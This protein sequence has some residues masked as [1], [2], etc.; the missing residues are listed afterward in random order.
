MQA[1][2]SQLLTLP[3]KATPSEASEA[4]SVHAAHPA[5]TSFLR[6]YGSEARVCVAT[7]LRSKYTK[8]NWRSKQKV[9]TALAK[10][11]RGTPAYHAIASL[12]SLASLASSEAIA[13]LEKQFQL[14]SG[15][16]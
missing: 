1:G 11:V 3:S 9:G 16:S 6:S 15:R 5:S 7:F 13:S 4:G 14:P 8:R 10:Q 12:A 2:Q